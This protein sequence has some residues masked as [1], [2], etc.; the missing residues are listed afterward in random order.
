MRHLLSNLF[1]NHSTE[2]IVHIVLLVLFLWFMEAGMG[3]SIDEKT[4]NTIRM[5]FLAF[6]ITFYFNAFVLIPTFLKEKKWLGYVGAMIVTI[7]VIEVLRSL[8]HLFVLNDSHDPEVLTF[9]QILFGKYAVSGGIFLG[10]LFSFAYKFTKDWLINLT[11]IERLKSER[12][13]MKLAFLK[14]QVNPHFLFNTLNNIYALA[15]KE[16]SPQTAEAITKL[17]TLMRY[18][19]EDAG[20]EKVLLSKEI[21]FIKK[22]VELQTMRATETDEIEFSVH[23]PEA[24]LT[25]Y[26]I[27]PLLMVPI[28]ENAF[29]YGINPSRKSLVSVNIE[30]N[31][32]KLLLNSKNTIA[33][34]TNVS[35][36]GIGL[37]NLE[38]RLSL[39]YP[40]KH[41]F[42]A[43]SMNGIFSTTLQLELD[44]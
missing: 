7:A 33:K 40:N 37:T 20:E 39:I 17:G 23:I 8:F 25:S 12:A 18:N 27:T 24:A 30:L 28:I 9:V 43:K 38:E 22:Y 34:E 29:K 13:E 31:G 21:D 3:T 19:L 36:S 11:F 15:L 42:E 5:N 6:P 35:S 14:T 32:D 1:K 16:D 44:S 41:L 10:F 4:K 26:F 2:T